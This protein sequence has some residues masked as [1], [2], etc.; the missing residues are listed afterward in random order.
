MSCPVC[1]S[2]RNTFIKKWTE[3][4]DALRCTNCD[5]VFASPMKRPADV[6][7]QAYTK[8]A[9]Y[10][11][12][13]KMAGSVKKN[14]TR[15]LGWPYKAFL[16]YVK[17]NNL[18]TSKNTVFEVGCGAGHFVYLM[19]KSG[20]TCRG[21]DISESACCA[22][23][24]LF[25]LDIIH[26]PFDDTAID[27]ASLDIVIAF[28]LLEHLEKPTVFLRKA[29][30]ALRDGGY[31]F[32]STPDAETKWPFEWSSEKTVMP[33]FHLTIFSRKSLTYA[34]EKNGFRIVDFIQ[35]P[36]PFRYEFMEKNFSFLSLL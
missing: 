24:N 1:G 22:A 7:S 10:D 5:L 32:L 27:D 12:Y 15:M 18:L 8:G 3:K 21:C 23:K 2:S 28:E 4:Y 20:Y 26:I 36:I 13:L 16:K 14:G 34:A 11:V 25:G 17:R 6:Y 35:K 9:E 33:P 19:N 30:S 31:L 29:N